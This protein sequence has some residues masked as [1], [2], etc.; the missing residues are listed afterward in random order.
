M[1]STPRASSASARNCFPPNMRTGFVAETA[2]KYEKLRLRHAAGRGAVKLLPLAEARARGHRFDWSPS[3]RP[4]P[5]A[6]GVRVLDHDRWKTFSP[7]WTGRHFSIPGACAAFTRKFLKAKNTASRRAS[8][9]PTRKNCSPASSR[10]NASIRA[11][12]SPHLAGQ[13]RGRQHVEIYA[14]ESR[15]RV[16]GT[17]PFSPPAKGKG[18]RPAL[19]M[20]GGFRRAEGIRRAGLG[21]R[22]R[23]HRRAGGG[24]LGEG[25][26][27][28]TA[29]TTPASSSR[30]WATAASRRSPNTCT[31]KFA[32]ELW[33]YAA[34][35]KL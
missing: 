3:R 30:H 35:E 10:K 18:Q 5:I 20:P 7:T 33:G 19:P 26:R 12:P 29:T 9:M 21:R 31:K 22:I 6:P 14:D 4:A 27:S 28:A 16:I 25:I 32:R 8:S 13:P 11:G 23:L 17:L 1:S 34:Q 15:A 2:A 24:H